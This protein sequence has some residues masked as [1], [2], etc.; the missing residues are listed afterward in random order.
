MEKTIRLTPR[1]EKTY[2][3]ECDDKSV[4]AD[5]MANLGV[6]TSKRFDEDIGKWYC[7]RIDAQRINDQMNYKGVG[8]CLK[9]KPYGYQRQAI[10]FCIQN[11][12]GLVRLPCGAG[13]FCRRKSI[14]PET[15]D[16]EDGIKRGWRNVS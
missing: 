15:S 12:Y 8:D 7:D 2:Y 10:A 5:F 6:V 13:K 1:D 16:Y 9:L 4:F 14:L 3:I 11:G